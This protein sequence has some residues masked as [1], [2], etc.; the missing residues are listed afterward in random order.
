VGG[1][2]QSS[3]DGQRSVITHGNV[4]AHVSGSERSVVL[5]SAAS[6]VGRSQTITVDH[7]SRIVNVS[8]GEHVMVSGGR[9]VISQGGANHLVLHTN[10]GG[11]EDPKGAHLETS[12]SITLSAGEAKITMNADGSGGIRIESPTEIKLV[13]GGSTLVL[14]PASIQANAKTFPA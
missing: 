11:A 7:G 8:E 12:H 13:V 14:S 4:H 5:G 10:D 2:Q 1:S 6:R 3:V 9:T